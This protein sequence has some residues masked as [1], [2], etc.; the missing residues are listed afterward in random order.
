MPRGGARPGAGRPKK[1]RDSGTAPNK[2]KQ[3]LP[4][5]D[6][7]GFKPED[8]GLSPFGRERPQEPTVAP[9]LDP[10]PEELANMSPLDYMLFVM[11]NPVVPLDMRMRAA[12]NA[13]PFCHAK[14]GEASAKK[15]EEAARKNAAQSGRFGRRQ[16]P[17]LTAVQGGKS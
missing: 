2:K 12:Q 6:A 8:A 3:A 15:D 5:T 4:D 16:P 10:P 1:P 14:K 13:L 17:S 7:D 11:R 9:P